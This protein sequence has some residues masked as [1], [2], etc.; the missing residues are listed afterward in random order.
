MGRKPRLPRADLAGRRGENPRAIRV[1]ARAGF[2]QEGVLRAHWFR[3]C[4]G[5]SV[6]LHLMGLM[7][8]EWLAAQR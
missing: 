5:R 6:D 3:P 2:R 8:G 1:Y 4:L 7:R